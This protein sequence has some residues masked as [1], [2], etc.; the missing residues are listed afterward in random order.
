MLGGEE[1]EGGRRRFAEGGCF[2]KARHSSHPHSCP[3][4]LIV[5]MEDCSRV[6]LRLWYD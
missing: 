1:D 3:K 5:F 2:S 4:S 6:C